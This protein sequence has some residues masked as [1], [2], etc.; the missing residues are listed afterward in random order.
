[1]AQISLISCW[2]FC[3]NFRAVQ[4]S[5]SFL[6]QLLFSFYR[7]CQADYRHA[8]SRSLA[9][10]FY[11]LFIARI[12]PVSRSEFSFGSFQ[13]KIFLSLLQDF[14][15]TRS[16]DAWSLIEFTPS[17]KQKYQVSFVTKI[18]TSRLICIQQTH[19]LFQTSRLIWSITK[20]NPQKLSKLTQYMNIPSSFIEE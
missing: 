2:G 7:S 5:R 17:E 15:R 9:R 3:R 11:G 18:K 14:L 19:S 1:M 10:H 20:P 6:V 8:L 12:L 16:D 4:T 13:I